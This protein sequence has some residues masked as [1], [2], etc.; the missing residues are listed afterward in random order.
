MSRIGKQNITLPAGTTI[1][2]DGKTLVVKGP[3]GQLERTFSPDV[4]IALAEN[5]VTVTPRKE[6]REFFAIWGTTASHIVNM[7]AG[8][9]KP[10]EKNLVLEG[11][12]FRVELKGTELV[13]QLGFSHPVVLKIPDGLSVSVEKNAIAISGIDKEL[14]GQ[15]AAKVR[16]QKPPEPYKGKGMR[17]ADEVIRRKEGK[18]AA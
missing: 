8:V 13:M 3:L 16:D 7:I 14:V 18:R 10:Y 4:S 17:Y 9:N 6:A 5:E 15:F 2:I 12:G 1:S 11:V